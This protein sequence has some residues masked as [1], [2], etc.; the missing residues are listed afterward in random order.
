MR[1][2]E[3]TIKLSATPRRLPLLGCAALVLAGLAGFAPVTGRGPATVVYRADFADG[4]GEEWSS[5]AF[6]DTPEGGRR[7]LGPFAGNDAV[8]LRLR[9]LP[10]HRT[11]TV[12]FDLYVIGSW[13]GDGSAGSGPDFW[14]LGLEDGTT[15]L[16]TTFSNYNGTNGIFIP[17]HYPNA[18][19]KRHPGRTGAVENDT[20]GY[21]NG[22]R[23]DAVYRLS[24]TFTHNRSDLS[25]QF[26][27]RNLQDVLDESWGIDNVEVLT[28]P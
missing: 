16:Q 5:R 4:P 17:Q 28:T 7:F 13:D 21:T 26:S 11:V 27:S 14:R 22:E 15:L 3:V 19:G 12:R 6:A 18:W 9:D 24:F 23:Q 20:L 25:L 8:T 1:R 2:K 10:A